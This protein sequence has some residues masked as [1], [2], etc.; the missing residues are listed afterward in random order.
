MKP[1][2]SDKYQSKNKIVLVEDNEI[3]S[4]DK[5]VTEILNHF[6]ITVTESDDIISWNESI[7]YPIESR[8]INV[9]SIA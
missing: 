9:A 2:L 6:F 5:K 7:I 4:D 3:I 8:Y 1:A